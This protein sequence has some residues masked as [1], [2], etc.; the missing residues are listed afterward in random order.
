MEPYT[1][2]V[3]IYDS[4]SP[5]GPLYLAVDESGRLLRCA[6]SPV[7][8]PGYREIPDW[9]RCSH[10][11]AQL[12]A[13]FTGSWEEKPLHAEILFTS[14]TSFQR[15]VWDSLRAIPV[16]TTVTYGQVAEAIGHPGASRAVGSAASAN[17]ILLF[18]PCHR[19]VTKGYHPGMSRSGGYRA[20]GSEAKEF[21]LELEHRHARSL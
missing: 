17:S 11:T 2:Y 21:L 14:G 20:G 5:L 7:P 9:E 15:S 8:I 19:V 13:Y 4:P 18:I 3:C 16:G 10:I 6:E 1:A 12:Q